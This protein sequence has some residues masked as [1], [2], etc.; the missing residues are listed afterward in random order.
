M[1][2]T[3]N[4]LAQFTNRQLKVTTGKKSKT[5]EKLSSGYRINRSADDAAGLQISEKM[6]AQIRGLK[7]GQRNIM[8]GVSWVQI[9]DGA[10][11]EVSSM[12]HRI[13]ELAVQAANDTN[14]DIDREAINEEITQIKKEINGIGKRTE[15]NKQQIFHNPKV[16]MD[17]D[18]SLDEIQI[19]NASYDDQTGDV[20]YG[21]FIF[22][23]NRINWN[24]VD[25]SMVNIDQTTGEQTFTAGTYTYTDATGQIFTLKCEDGAKVPEISR[26]AQVEASNA[27]IMIDNELHTWSELK[28]EDGNSASLGNLAGGVYT[29]T[30]GNATVAFF[31]SEE[32]TSL[33]DFVDSINSLTD[34]EYK[35]TL[36]E[37]YVEPKEEQAVDANLIR[38]L[39]INNNVA[40]E[41]VNNQLTYIVGADE[42]GIW[43]E[44]K[45]GTEIADSKRTWADLGIN[46]WDSGDDIQE[47][48]T[49]QYSD[50][51]GTND[52][53]IAFDF[54]LS[55]VTSVDSIV[56]GLDGMV[57][58]GNTIKTSY[59][60]DVKVQND[61][62]NPDEVVDNILKFEYKANGT[63]SFDEEKNLGRDF[64]TQISDDIAISDSNM[65]IGYDNATK[66][67]TLQLNATSQNATSASGIIYEGN[68]TN[69]TAQMQ[70]DINKY[71]NYVVTQKTSA[72]LN[73][74]SADAV[75]LGTVSLETVLG[76]D[77]ITTGGTFDTTVTLE[78]DTSMK[79]TDGEPGYSS[80][81]VGQTY[82]TAFINF[83]DL[84]DSTALNGLL[85]TGFNSTCKTCDN[86]Y[87]IVFTTVSDASATTMSNGYKYAKTQNSL[88]HT[89]EI[90]L[91]SLIAN[92]VNNGTDLADAIVTIAGEC[93]DFHYTQ[94]ASKDG[95]LYVYDNREQSTGTADATFDP[96]PYDPIDTDMYTFALETGNG[97]SLNLDYTYC[98]G[99]IAKFVEVEMQKNTQGGGEYVAI[100]DDPTNP[101]K[102]TRY[103]KYDSAVHGST[104]ERYDLEI[105]YGGVDNSDTAKQT[106]IESYT[107]TA[108]SEIL[109][110]TNVSFDATNY[111]YIQLDGDEKDNVA[112]RSI[113]ETEVIPPETD[114][115][116]YIQYSGNPYDNIKIP[117]F[118]LNTLDLKLYNTKVDTH[119]NANK[120]IEFV[121][122]AL[123]KLL[124]KRSTYGAYQNR[125]E[126]AYAV[127][128]NIEENTQASESRI[129]DANMALEVLENT[130]LNILQQ[131]G[132]SMLAQANQNP[133]MILQ[134]LQQ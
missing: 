77:K 128:G 37:R 43:L 1:I 26:I 88:H 45:N 23:G 41:I 107:D 36:Q 119:E 92:G 15:Y 131:A 6:R 11:E 89:L 120:T 64:D 130:K 46:S 50:S 87:S 109:K 100:K 79:K 83:S 113:F 123:Q 98:Y 58:S 56:D 127:Q 74:G 72:L 80:G 40:N 116:I 53:L 22:N 125:L 17:V 33:D 133:Q 57:I 34:Y 122:K 20:T 54:S 102:I 63:L 132:Q 67:I 61:D 95:T 84:T 68:A 19:F 2:V 38:N 18:G 52:T 3:H 48:I 71:V 12:L 13:K 7:M 24:M 112:I 60:T 42:T 55:E 32:F 90:D 16:M 9:G 5:T 99:D 62:T 66:E 76:S 108:I 59:H 78:S 114:Y 14:A 115:G 51:D 29:L 10:M 117:K 25:Q 118:A 70:H 104:V 27:G 91:N 69:V 44:D 81:T 86:H 39:R 124:S 8:E 129:R 31:F 97:K 4:L 47:T 103:E 49:Y 35:Y 96:F 110:A 121:D 85:E 75:T 73:L 65:N 21:G 30:H 101:D 94:Y 106:M 134:L 82:P 105:K 111:S 28:D 126:H 93:F